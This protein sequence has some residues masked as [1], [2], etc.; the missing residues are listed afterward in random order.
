VNDTAL[1]IQRLR[2]RAG[3]RLVVDEVGFSAWPGKVTAVI[4]PNGAGKTSL[5]EA[6]IGLRG[7]ES[8]VIRLAGKSLTSF[9]ER[10]KTFAY[11]PDQAELPA[12]AR[13]A[14][15]IEHALSHGAAA[16]VAELRSLLAIEP[17]LERG[18]GVLSRGERQRVLLFS[19]L[20]LAR[21]VVV[22][23]EPF[24]AFDPLQLRDVHR[25]IRYVTASGAAVVASIHQLGDAEKIADRV[26]LLAEGRAV[27]F[28]TPAE[29]KLRAGDAAMPL[30]EVFVALLTRRSSAA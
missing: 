5:L 28:G 7:I 27:A 22:L 12:E 18:A 21:P 24:S 8:G 23:D 25:A 29:L 16:D 4:G 19:T 20:V 26:L 9:R 17:L 2:V 11:L 1:V 6:I 14:T 15:L 3:S 30:E 10:A 13:V